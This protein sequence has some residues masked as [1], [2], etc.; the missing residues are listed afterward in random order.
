M[1]LYKLSRFLFK[2]K[3]Y[4]F[5]NKVDTF[6]KVINKCVIQGETNISDGFSLGYG[7]IGVVIH[8][9]AIIGSNCTVSQ[10]VTIGRKKGKNEGVPKIGN[11]VYIG[12]NSVIF[13]NVSI[14]DNCIIGPCTLVNK[15]IPPNSIVAGNPFKLITRITK[16]NY[17]EYSSYNI[18]YEKL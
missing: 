18:D 4:Y 8:R 17:S 11:N 1:K 7:G 6:N 13:G 15:S 14:G 2:R 12:A 3:L 9:N 5:S 16:E 10:N